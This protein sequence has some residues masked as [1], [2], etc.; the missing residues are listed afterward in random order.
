[1]KSCQRR[2]EFF[3]YK[4]LPVYENRR[5]AAM[6]LLLHEAIYR[7]VVVE[8]LPQTRKC[9]WIV[10]ADIKDLHVPKGRR[11]VTLPEFIRW[12]H[13]RPEFPVEGCLSSL[14]LAR[15]CRLAGPL[16][17]PPVKRKRRRKPR[18]VVKAGAEKPAGEP[19]DPAAS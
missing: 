13:R 9:L 7:R 12:L 11:F 3:I 16:P 6:E 1:M 8:L 5:Q 4:R 19:N 14:L 10:T 15:K 18:G 2:R 17:G